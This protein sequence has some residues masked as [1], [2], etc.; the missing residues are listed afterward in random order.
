M[1]FTNW[2]LVVTVLYLVLAIASTN[3]RS[4]SLLALH[5]IWFEISFMMNIIVVIVFWSTL[6]KDAISEC[7][8]DELRIWNVY[9]AHIIPGASVFINFIFTDVTMTPTHYKMVASISILYGYVNYLE[10][11]K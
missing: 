5:H 7:E 6:Y 2:T 1:Y 3:T 9:F 8:G 11:I 4:L 10:T